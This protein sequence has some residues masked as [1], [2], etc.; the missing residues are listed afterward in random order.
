MDG[1][2]CSIIKHEVTQSRYICQVFAF[3]SCPVIQITTA[4]HTVLSSLS[5]RSWSLYKLSLQSCFLNTVFKYRWVRK[6][7][8]DLVNTFF[9]FC[10]HLFSGWQGLVTSPNLRPDQKKFQTTWNAARVEHV[11]YKC[12]NHLQLGKSAWNNATIYLMLNGFQY[13][14]RIWRK[15]RALA[16]GQW[17][18]IFVDICYGNVAPRQHREGDAL[19]TLVRSFISHTLF[20]F[21][22]NL[23]CLREPGAHLIIW[24]RQHKV[25]V[26]CRDQ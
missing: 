25:V 12:L 3:S 8:M 9:L 4:L 19:I 18:D 22:P 26:W 17:M 14:L 15:Q 6:N 21:G 11:C 10:S 1:P 13:N 20:N 16:D 7:H 24:P 23:R 5:R 2:L